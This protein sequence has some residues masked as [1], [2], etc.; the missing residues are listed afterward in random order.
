MEINKIAT[1]QSYGEALVKIGREN[2]QIV[3]FD[4]DLSTATY[5]KLFAKEFPERFFDMGIAEQNM[6]GTAA[7]MS[8]CGKIPYVS[9]FAVFACRKSI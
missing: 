8:T 4:A 7:G 6:V 2:E 3:V 1:R 5:T 9:T